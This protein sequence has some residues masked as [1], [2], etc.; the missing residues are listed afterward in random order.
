MENMIGAVAVVGAY[1]VGS[2]SSA[3]LICRIFK[4]PDPRT[5]GSGNPGATNVMRLGGRIPAALTLCG[6]VLKGWLPVFLVQFF[7]DNPL[8]VILTLLAA[9]CGHLFP[10]FFK[11]KGG[12]GVATA[13]GGIAGLSLPLAGIFIATWCGVFAIFRISSLSALI[14][15]ASLPGWALFLHPKTYALG[16]L[17]LAI[18]I[19]WRHKSN[20]ERLLQGKEGKASK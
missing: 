2:I 3:I 4:L 19:I 10:I 5:Q 1:L 12:K 15:I 9:V 13:L 17:L 20:I 6:D 11:F 8:I 14:A 7:T 18:I 16:L